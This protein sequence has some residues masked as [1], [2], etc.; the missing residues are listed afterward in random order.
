M[1]ESL[2]IMLA[3]QDERMRMLLEE[4]RDS[5]EFRKTMYHQ[6]ETFRNEMV[7]MNTRMKSVETSLATSAP[8]IE[9]FITIKHKVIG[10]GVAGK[11][12][13]AFSAFIVGLLFSLRKELFSWFASN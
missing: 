2:E 4:G 8:T 6:L 10:A 9:E 7:M 5:K 13:W 12:V 1:G 3:R 11:W